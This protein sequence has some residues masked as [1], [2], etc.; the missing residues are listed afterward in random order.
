MPSGPGKPGFVRVALK[1]CASAIKAAAQSS[2]FFYG[3][4]LSA[5]CQYV[6]SAT[7]APFLKVYTVTADC[8]MLPASSYAYV[9][10]TPL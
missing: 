5:R 8:F 9:P 7:G 10:T 1:P 6:A 2:G 3:R 4:R